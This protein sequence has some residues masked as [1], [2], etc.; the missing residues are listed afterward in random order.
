LSKAA[1]GLVGLVLIYAA[2]LMIGRLVARRRS[3]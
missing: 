2:C 3:V 1:A